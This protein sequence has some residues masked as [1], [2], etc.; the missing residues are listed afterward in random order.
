MRHLRSRAGFIKPLLT[1]IILVLAGYVGIEFGIPYYRYS[2]F[3]SEATAIARLELGS[4]D[5]TRTQ[6]YQ[7]AQELKL[8]IEEKDIVVT[9]KLH[10]VRVQTSWSSTVDIFGLYQ[11]TL[12]FTI[13]LEE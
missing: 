8:P 3:K 1:I 2:S 7:A 9:R 4:V 10:T 11:K 5:K 6:I 12:D 13:D